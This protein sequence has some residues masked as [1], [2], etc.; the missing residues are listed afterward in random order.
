MSVLVA[1]AGILEVAG[2]GIDSRWAVI[3][4]VQGIFAW[5]CVHG[6]VFGRSDAG[7][8][9]L[10]YVLVPES[11]TLAP[12]RCPFFGAACRGQPWGSP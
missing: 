9:R 2:R 12:M 10:R 4:A 8:L 1:S 7:Q 3:F 11:G 6:G 5:H